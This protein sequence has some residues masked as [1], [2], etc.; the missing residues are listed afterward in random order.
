MGVE[1]ECS[2]AKW[3]YMFLR[4]AEMK[5]YANIFTGKEKVAVKVGN[6]NSEDSDDEKRT[7][8]FTVCP[9]TTRNHKERFEK[10]SYT[11]EEFEE[12]KKKAELIASAFDNGFIEK[13][14]DLIDIDSIKGDGYLFVYANK[15]DLDLVLAN[16]LP[17]QYLITDNTTRQPVVIPANEMHVFL[18]FYQSMPY[19]IEILEHSLEE[20]T[21]KKTKIRITAGVFAGKEGYLMK[22]HK[23]SR[24]VFAL[25]SMTIAVSYLGAFPF[26]KVE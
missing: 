25:G 24:L 26:E 8:H 7:F 5:R 23:N 3:Y 14:N 20:F 15:E 22:L 11:K 10:C 2:K 21:K 17:R 1:K 6:K 9:Y 4:N 13:L 18:Y 12:R 19:N 16:T